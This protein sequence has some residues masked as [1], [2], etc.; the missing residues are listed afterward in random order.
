MTRLLRRAGGS[1]ATAG[2]QLDCEFRANAHLPDQQ[3]GVGGDA[4]RISVLK[5]WSRRERGAGA[6]KIQ[7]IGMNEVRRRPNS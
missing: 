6:D 5:E 7:S 3:S 4:A 1:G 2:R